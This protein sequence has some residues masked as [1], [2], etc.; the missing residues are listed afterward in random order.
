[1]RPP[2]LI[3]ALVVAALLATMIAWAAAPAG[4]WW[5]HRSSRY[6]E[7]IAWLEGLRPL[8]P[9]GAALDPA[10]DRL[11][12]DR[13]ARELSAG[14][15]D[16][17]VQ[18]MREARRR[19]LRPGANRDAKLMEVGLETYAAASDRV[20]RHGRLSLAADWCDTLFVFA[21]RDSDPDI[22]MHASA[23]FVEGLDLRVQ[24]RKPC[25]AL[26]RWSWAKQGLGGE[27]PDVSPMIEQ[28]LN[29]RCAYARREGWP[30]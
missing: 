19:Q 3:A 28:E 4:A 7:E 27:I 15:V 26:A 5:L 24:D 21:I 20:R 22:R 6:D 12:V 13:V 23:A 25:D 29:A 18:A 17:A 9:F 1:V 2:V 30:Q 11:H 8:L 10:I 14:R 16:R